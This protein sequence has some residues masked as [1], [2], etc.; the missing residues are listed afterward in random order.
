MKIQY[1]HASDPETVKIFD[2]VKVYH[3]PNNPRV[4]ATQEDFD[5]F[6]LGHFARDKEQ[7]TII[8]YEVVEES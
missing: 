3:N 4:F 6:E 1:I 7:G 2:T 5:N 8:S